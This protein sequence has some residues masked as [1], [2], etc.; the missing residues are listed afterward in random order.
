MWLFNRLRERHKQLFGLGMED[1]LKK[2]SF[3]EIRPIPA[4][5]NEDLCE[6]EDI[7]DIQQCA[8]GDVVSHL[9]Q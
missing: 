7:D 4:L 6:H 3:W 5:K 1:L 2:N 9:L 8:D